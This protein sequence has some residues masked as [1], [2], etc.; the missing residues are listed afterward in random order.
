MRLGAMP[1]SV[2][3]KASGS[4]GELLYV[5][6]GPNDV[7]VFTVPEGKLVQILTGVSYPQLQCSDQQGDVFIADDEKLDK[8][9]H[10]GTTPINVLY[11]NPGV[12]PGQCAVD[13]TTG[14]VAL[15]ASLNGGGQVDIFSG[16]QGKPTVYTDP[17]DAQYVAP[18][19]DQHGNLYVNGEDAN[20]SFLLAEMRK[21]HDT[22]TSISQ[23][24]T[25]RDPGS[26][27]WDGHYLVASGAPNEANDTLFLFKVKGSS[28]KVVN[29]LLLE[30]ST[31]SE[32][33]IE[34]GL[35]TAVYCNRPHHTRCF[36]VGFWEYP[37]G[38]KRTKFIARSNF[39]MR[40]RLWGMT[41]SVVPSGNKIHK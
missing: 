6:N 21:G 41:I 29:S 15:T 14:T 30:R 7:R 23:N 40:H 3:H 27:Q 32:T 24:A 11:V 17:S 20:G 38:G 34:G 18:A 37:E 10:G 9:A 35:V 13:P 26:L 2:A 25:I 4:Y 33:W 28:A 39:N 5:S 8:F 22:F 19:Y 12:T 31:R 16:G 1:Q 36:S